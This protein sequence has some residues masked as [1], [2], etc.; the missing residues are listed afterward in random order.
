MIELHPTI[1]FAS[2]KLIDRCREIALPAWHWDAKHELVEEP[3]GWGE[4]DA[5]L[6]APMLR[7]L[8]CLA[9]STWPYPTPPPTTELFPGLWIVA[10][11]ETDVDQRTSTTAFLALGPEAFGTEQY[12]SIC[13][14]AGL[15]PEQVRHALGPMARHRRVGVDER[16]RLIRWMHEDLVRE[17]EHDHAIRN[18]SKQLVDM[19]EQMNLLYR[20]GELMNGLDDPNGFVRMACGLLLDTLEFEWIAVRFSSLQSLGPT[21]ANDLVLVGRIPCSHTRYDRLAGDLAAKATHEDRPTILDPG[22]AE[23]AALVGSEVFANPLLCDNQLAGVL[24]A[25]NKDGPDP[26]I[27]SVEMQLLSATADYVSA[28]LHNA[29][30]YNDQRTTFL[31]IIKALSASIDAKDRYTRGHSERVA[32]LASQIAL[33][34]G[35]TE[36]QTER[37]RLAGILHDM[38]K[39]GVPE[40]V[41]LKP[42]RLTD[43]EFEAIKLHPTIGYNILK[44]I[45]PLQDVLPGVLYHHER[46]DGGGYPHGLRGHGIPLVGRIL[47]VADAFDAMSSDRA[48]RPR[49]AREA[50]LREMRNGA[51][52]QWDSELIKIFLALDLSKYDA[53]IDRH[54]AQSAKAA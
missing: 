13:R 3:S 49:M 11:T 9:K 12:A 30:L 8:V 44:D 25:G 26:A 46:W 2:R 19:Y 16:S 38:G 39:I 36:D 42:G 37:V 32:H 43:E 21:M 31:G 51:G 10:V 29:A 28:Y 22:K 40:N 4:A 20:V 53:M 33:A 7:D 6:R 24:L 35:M 18:F 27:S 34:S 48:Y 54:A 50:V 52:K 45:E 47:A 23:L 14:S 1:P 5:W 17:A 15:S 41:L